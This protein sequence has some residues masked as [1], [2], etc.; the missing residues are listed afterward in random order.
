MEG[1]DTERCDY[2]EQVLTA[3]LEN[4]NN[5]F[6]AQLAGSGKSLVFQALTFAK[7]LKAY[8]EDNHQQH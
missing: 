1:K 5:V 4:K 8:V 6:L 2:L 3:I 7:H